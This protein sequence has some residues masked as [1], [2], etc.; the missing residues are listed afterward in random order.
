MIDQPDQLQ[1]LLELTQILINQQE[2]VI[3]QQGNILSKIDNIQLFIK[4]IFIILA[5]TCG[6]YIGFVTG[7]D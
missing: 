6:F 4:Y 3:N 5:L 1:Q 7:K 2:T